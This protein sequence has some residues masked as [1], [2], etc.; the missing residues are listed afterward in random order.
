MGRAYNRKRV[1]GIDRDRWLGAIC[2]NRRAPC[3]APTGEG[4]SLGSRR[5]R[6]GLRLSLCL[7]LPNDILHFLGE[8]RPLGNLGKA[9]AI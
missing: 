1:G 6:H 7:N 8:I 2:P 4:R 3:C 5:W 9:M